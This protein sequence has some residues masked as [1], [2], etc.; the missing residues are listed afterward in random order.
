MTGHNGAR[1][2]ED[3][4]HLFTGSTVNIAAAY[5]ALARRYDRNLR[6]YLGYPVATDADFPYTQGLLAGRFLNNISTEQ[7]WPPGYQHAM[8]AE[9][10]VLDWLGG[11]LGL[12]P[13][14]RWGHLTT[15]GTS[16]NRTAIR[17][18]RNLHPDATLIHSSAAHYSVPGAAADLRIQTAAVPA[19][20]NGQ[21][22]LDRLDDT[23]ARLAALR[24]PGDLPLIVVATLG[25]TL[26]EASDDLA[27]I[28]AVLNAHHIRRRH[29]HADAALAGIPQAL[30]GLITLDK[31]DSVSVSAY[32]FLAVPAACGIILGRRADHHADA[33]I[34]G[35]TGTLNATETG[36]RSGLHAALLFE[37]IHQHGD[38]GHRTRAHTSRALADHTITRLAEIGVPAWRNP[39]AYFTVVLDSPP[40]P[41]LKKW[42]LGPNGD[43]THRLVLVPGKTQQQ[44]DEFLGDLGTALSSNH[45]VPAPRRNLFAAFTTQE[46]TR[47]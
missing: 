2:G 37:A 16:G 30:D 5:D 28:A 35:Y 45:H 44:I 25:T 29:V 9:T 23:I 7:R 3:L 15:G 14:Q 43:G 6:Y 42:T 31:A 41:V 4:T 11:H 12:P 27:G 38:T 17:Y 34:V 26:T 47:Q 40:E 1:A 32:K 10:A 46:Q 20:P 36:V 22:N 18:A 8:E 33:D 13:D 39:S 24:A 21:M 19:H